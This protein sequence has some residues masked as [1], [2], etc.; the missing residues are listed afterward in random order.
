MV[1]S[2]HLGVGRTGMARRMG[3]DESCLTLMCPRAQKQTERCHPEETRP[4][5]L[6]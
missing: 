2:F 1:G 3:W 5:L 4:P 6:F